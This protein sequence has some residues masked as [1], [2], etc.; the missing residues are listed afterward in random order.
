MPGFRGRH[1]SDSVDDMPWTRWTACP[2]FGGRLQAESAPGDD[3]VIPAI[4]YRF[5]TDGYFET[6]GIRVVRGRGLE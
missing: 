5:A 3:E 2:G 1:P 6:L 4:P